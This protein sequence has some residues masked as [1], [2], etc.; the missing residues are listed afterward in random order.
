M[1]KVGIIGA[2]GYTGVELLRL[3]APRSDVEIT[4]VTSRELAGV[5]VHSR[6]PNL[7]GHVDLQ[8]C[9]PN[10]ELLQA[11]DVVFYAT[12]HA[13]AMNTVAELLSKGI[14]VIDLSADFRI[15][16]IP[17]WEQW[18]KTKHVC[19]ELVAG[20][21]YGLPEVNREKIKSAQLI[22]VPGCY[23]TA[24]Q[25]GFLPLLENSLIETDRLIADAKSGVSG[26]GRKAVED[27]LLCEATE[28]IKAYGLSGHRHHPEICERLNT[29]SDYEVQLTFI[30]HLVPMIRGI[31]AT[32][33]APVKLGV[34]VS[35]DQLQAVYE[36]RY[37]DEPFVDVLPQ[38]EVPATRNVKGSNK[39]Q[40]AVAYSEDTNTIVVLS[41]EDNLVKGAA[42]QAIQNMNIMF[43]LDETTGLQNIALLP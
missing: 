30:P 29:Y 16:D 20:A 32:L 5:A 31:L 23:P 10:S 1:I 43:G 11:C 37:A 39:C 9:A 35:L 19:P 2:T 3:L 26:A 18:Y 41:A 25:L 21:V 7:R 38:G 13:V 36:Q 4:V 34:E 14:K 22:A 40:I 33:Y 8:F 28:S 24:I 15:Q 6:F 12:P 17:L 42:G 27:F